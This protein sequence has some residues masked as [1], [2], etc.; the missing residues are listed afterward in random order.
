MFGVAALT[1]LTLVAHVWVYLEFHRSSFVINIEAGVETA[2]G[3]MTRIIK[4]GTAIP[5]RKTQIF[6]TTVDDQTSVT[7]N[8]FAGE[9][10]FVAHNKKFGS[11][12]LSDL[13]TLPRGEPKVGFIH[14]SDFS[15][16][17]Q[18]F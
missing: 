6:T 13:K 15:I 1:R 9:R 11:L 17:L 4:R 8:M 3:I 7:V 10:S 18:L 14:Q 2:G 16:C 12:E 5:T